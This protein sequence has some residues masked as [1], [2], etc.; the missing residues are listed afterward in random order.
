LKLWNF[1]NE[2]AR[3][4]IKNKMQNPKEYLDIEGEVWWDSFYNEE[5]EKEKNV[6]LI[7]KIGFLNTLWKYIRPSR[8]AVSL[9]KKGEEYLQLE[10]YDRARNTFEQAGMFDEKYA[11][12]RINIGRIYEQLDQ[13]ERALETYKQV[14]EM[15]PMNLQALTAQNQIY[16]NMDR[17]EEAEEVK[18]KMKVIEEKG[19]R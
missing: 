4:T 12:P 11:D 1:E 17:L 16:E 6:G 8:V 13:P 18:K 10:Q 15:N 3:F 7:C 14:E 2:E 5:D 19:K 9:N